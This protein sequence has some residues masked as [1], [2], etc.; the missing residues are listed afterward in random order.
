MA[1]DNPPEPF[2]DRDERDFPPTVEGHTSMTDGHRLH[3]IDPDEGRDI[4]VFDG[5]EGP[6]FVDE[7]VSD[8]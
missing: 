8:E 4:D 2:E 7:E 5:D 1:R 3:T 6:R